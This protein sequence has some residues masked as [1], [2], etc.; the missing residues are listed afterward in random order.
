M[1]V[2]REILQE[3]FD[4]GSDALVDVLV[5]TFENGAVV[6]TRM[7]APRLVLSVD[8]SMILADGTD[9]AL[10]TATFETCALVDN[11]LVWSKVVPTGD[12]TFVVNLRETRV[13]IDATG[14][15]LLALST[16]IAG[17]YHV[18]A[19]FADYGEAHA[20]VEAMV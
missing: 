4:I 13:G 12:V 3:A 11:E 1:E 19:S 10:L 6:K 14:K 9:E 18:K 16:T 5:E 20:A 15:A 7:P 8:K 2:T 17:T